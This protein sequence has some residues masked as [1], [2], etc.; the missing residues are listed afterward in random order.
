M[1]KRQRFVRLFV[2]YKEGIEHLGNHF[3]NPGNFKGYMQLDL[4]LHHNFFFKH[5]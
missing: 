3:R 5:L 4:E 2:Y 1:A